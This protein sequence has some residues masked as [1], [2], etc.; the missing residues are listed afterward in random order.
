[1]LMLSMS[2][3]AIDEREWECRKLYREYEKALA[4]EENK[5]TCNDRCMDDY[6]SGLIPNGRLSVCLSG[7]AGAQLGGS[8]N[9]S[10]IDNLEQQLKDNCL[11]YM[12]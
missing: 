2:A 7:C 6:R 12:E 4:E 9:S 3:V 10:A 11:E 8:L 5:D 1:M